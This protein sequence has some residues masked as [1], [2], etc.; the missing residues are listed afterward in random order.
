M[1]G[2]ITIEIHGKEEDFTRDVLFYW[3]GYRSV[4]GTYIERW[5]RCMSNDV[6]ACNNNYYM[7]RRSREFAALDGD[8]HRAV[9]EGFL[10]MG[11]L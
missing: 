6:H 10:D 3:I 8:T 7:G 2:W 11:R 1:I 9:L 5:R 4:F